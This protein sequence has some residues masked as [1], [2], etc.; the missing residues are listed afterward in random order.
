MDQIKIGKF[1]AELRKKENLTQFELAERLGITD[2]AVSKWERGL[3]LPDA[4]IMLELCKILKITVN[5]LLNGG[6]IMENKNENQEIILDLVK[7]KQEAD[8]MLLRL[9]IVVGITCVIIMLTLFMIAGFVQMADW[10]RI[11]LILVGLLPLLVAMPFMIKI[12]QKA[13]Y[14]VCR[15][16]KHKYIPS[17][18]SVFM[19]MHYGRTRYMKCPKCGKLTW[20]KKVID[21]E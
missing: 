7:Q 20:Q 17:Y 9:E 12:E 11:V 8:K 2:R 1:I 3:A 10:L 14:Y 5:D 16:C 6:I 21:N 19:S 18:S 4:S 15:N 13:G